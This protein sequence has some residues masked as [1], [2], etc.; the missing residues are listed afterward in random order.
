MKDRA[1]TEPA[2]LRT[3][4]ERHLWMPYSPPGRAGL[5]AR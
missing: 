5:R 3:L 1:A 2:D 4:A